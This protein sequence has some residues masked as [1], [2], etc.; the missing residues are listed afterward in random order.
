MK[1]NRTPSPPGGFAKIPNSLLRDRRLSFKAR[2][3]IA[4]LLSHTDGWKAA[5]EQLANEGPDGRAA[6]LTGLKELAKAGYMVRTK[7]RIERG[8]WVTDIEIWDTAQPPT[9]ENRTSGGASSQVA[10]EADSPTS[11]NRHVGEPD[12]GSPNVSW[13]NAGPPAAVVPED[14]DE[15]QE[16]VTNGGTL[17]PD[18]L[19]PDDP[20]GRRTDYL[21][22]LSDPSQLAQLLQ[23]D[24]ATA[25]EAPSDRGP[26]EPTDGF[27]EQMA[28]QDQISS[29]AECGCGTVFDP[30]GSCF[31]CRTPATRRWRIA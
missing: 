21:D 3:M 16:E 8:Q 18:P 9:S 15:D 4:Y 10:P 25:R 13:P 30:D 11:D 20:S 2:G 5:A 14:Q 29:S 24:P 28:P 27:V 19:R 22:E 12:V 6:I 31:V 7:R 23:G 17:P 26:I 1:I